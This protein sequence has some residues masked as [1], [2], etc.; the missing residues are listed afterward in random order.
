MGVGSGVTAVTIAAKGVRVTGVDINPS[1]VTN[2]QENAAKHGVETNTEFFVSDLFE[3]LT[4]R[5]FDTIYWNIPFCC[6]TKRSTNLLERSIYDY[7]YRSLKAFFR[8]AKNYLKPGGQIYIGF[9]NTIGDFDKLAEFV[10]KGGFSTMSVVAQKE[11][12]WKDI[13]TDLTLYCIT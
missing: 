9:S 12:T 1:A 10:K 13:E 4:K 6:A 3:G 2:A 5:K 11:F 8:S 7:K